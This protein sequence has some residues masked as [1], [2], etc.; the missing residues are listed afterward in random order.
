MIFD[1]TISC[2]SFVLAQSSTKV[3]ASFFD[4]SS[5][6]VAALITRKLH[7]QIHFK[8]HICKII[9]QT[10]ANSHFAKIFKNIHDKINFSTL[11]LDV[12]T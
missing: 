11:C 3:S 4:V 5:L 10:L 2:R 12:F 6:A 7:K 8:S 9:C 1:V